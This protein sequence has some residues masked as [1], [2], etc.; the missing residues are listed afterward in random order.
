MTDHVIVTDEDNARIITMRRPDKKNA[1]TQGMYIAMAD[2]I[3][4]A[5]NDP[6][7]RSIVISG[8]SGVFTAGNDIEDFAKANTA[9]DDSSRPMAATQFL[10]ALA[11]NEKPLIGAVDGIAVGRRGGEGGREQGGDGGEYGFH[12]LAPNRNARDARRWWK[13]SG[14][15]HGRDHDHPPASWSPRR[16]RGGGPGARPPCGGRG[17]PRRR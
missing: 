4:S 10:K 14:D 9:N 16:H 13:L 5:Q 1:L 11:Y 17:G 2:A 7:I 6:D 15:F 8:G 3:K 12:G